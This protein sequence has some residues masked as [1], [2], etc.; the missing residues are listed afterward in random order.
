[1]QRVA[2]GLPRNILSRQDPI[3]GAIKPC[4]NLHGP[5]L[6]KAERTGGRILFRSSL[7]K[8]TAVDKFLRAERQLPHF[9]RINF[10]SFA[11]KNMTLG[12]GPPGP[13]DDRI[14][15]FLSSGLAHNPP[16]YLPR[17]LVPGDETISP[18]PRKSWK[19][20]FWSVKRLAT[21]TTP[22][23]ENRAARNSSSKS[24]A[25]VCDG[26]QCIQRKRNRMGYR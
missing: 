23:A 25:L 8:F 2:F 6:P 13:G 19:L 7:E 20:C 4:L 26:T 1:M 11:A 14:I 18:W 16:Q 9:P 17:A 5:T 15:V 3:P 10:L 22:S 12:S 24:T 21:T